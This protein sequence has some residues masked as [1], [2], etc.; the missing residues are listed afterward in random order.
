MHRSLE[1]LEILGDLHGGGNINSEVVQLEI[2]EIE[3]QVKFERMQGAKSYWDLLHPGVI[4]R[5]ALGVFLQMWSQLS[6]INTM[7]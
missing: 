5:V 3:D 4:R 2:A 7:M 1:A 6:G